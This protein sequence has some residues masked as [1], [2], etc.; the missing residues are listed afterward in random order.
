LPLI[1]LGPIG[2]RLA[3][4][5]G[6]FKIATLG[7]LFGALF[8]FL[9]GVMPTGGLIFT[10]A[11]VHSVFDGLTVSSTGV[12]V[13]LTVPQDRQAGAQGVL[14]AAQALA[15]GA[16]AV[17]TGSLYEASGRVAAYSMC[18]LTMV[19]FVGIGI[20]LARSEWTLKRAVGDS[21]SDGPASSDVALVPLH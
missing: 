15:A 21:A 2:G 12:A 7:L 11:M 1:V 16:M 17:I 8:M 9:Y 3:Q 10:V 18:A 5:I 4:T 14:G 6:P 19:A 20:W 13:G